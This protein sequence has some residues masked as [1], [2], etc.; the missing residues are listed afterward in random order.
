MLCAPTN[1]ELDQDLRKSY[2]NME[3]AAKWWASSLEN[4]STSDKR[5]GSIPPPSATTRG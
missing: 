5:R 4:C 1:G 2:S 3:G